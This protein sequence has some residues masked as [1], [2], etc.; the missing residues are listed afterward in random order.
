MLKHVR[1][2][3][4]TL[5]RRDHNLFTAVLV[6]LLEIRIA[7]VVSA[8]LVTSTVV[9]VPTVLRGHSIVLVIVSLNICGVSVFSPAP[10][11]VDEE[12]Y[13]D[14]CQRSE[15]GSYNGGSAA[16]SIVAFVIVRIER[17]SW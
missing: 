7:L 13:T 3:R 8:I 12:N 15:N 11:A 2:C 9:I 6:F 5:L 4:G 10:D 17:R 14:S 16:S 1:L